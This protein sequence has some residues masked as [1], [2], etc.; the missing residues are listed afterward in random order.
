M[1]PSE[2]IS[3]AIRQAPGGTAVVAFVTASFPSRE[4]P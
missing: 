3:A 2:K 4:I 1:K